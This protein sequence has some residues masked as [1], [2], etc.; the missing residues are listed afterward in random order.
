[1]EIAFVINDIGTE[2]PNYTTVHLALKAHRMGHRVALLGVGD[3]HYTPDGHM[4]GKAYRP[5]KGSFRT[6][7]QFLD[8]CR[9]TGPA[10]IS[11]AELDVLMLRN[12]PNDDVVLRPW[13]QTAGI[14]FGQVAAAQGVLVVNDPF[15]LSAAMNKMYFQHYPEAIRPRTLITRNVEEIAAFLKEQQRIILKPLQ[16]SGGRSVFIADGNNRGNH[17]QIID[18][19]ARDGFVIAQEYLPEA[20]NGD[21]RLFVMNGS[22]LE[23][24]GRYAA[25]RRVTAEGDIRSNLKAGG[26]PGAVEMT[27]ELLALVEVVRP[28][29]LM[30]GMF[31]VGLDIVGNKLMEINVLSPGTLHY[32]VELEKVDFFETII[33]S[34]ERKVEYRRL[35]GASIANRQLAVM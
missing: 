16:G 12:D 30:D 18:A 20:K 13:A 35:H 22:A 28:K 8:A 29:L 5:G 10:V 6:T 19:I 31:L 33:A 24:D 2:S 21:I 32:I 15:S 9:K 11:S 3:L 27:D 14:V 17:H 4:G 1:M 23:R 34:L 26:K 25:F 7:N